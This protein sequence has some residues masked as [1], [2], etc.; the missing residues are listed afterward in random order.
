MGG[1]GVVRGDYPLVRYYLPHLIYQGSDVWGGTYAR[2]NP[3][4]FFCLWVTSDPHLEIAKVCHEHGL[5]G[6]LQRW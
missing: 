5:R 4:L 2:Y 1:H 6:F 3:T